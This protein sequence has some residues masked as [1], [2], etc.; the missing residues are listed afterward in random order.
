MVLTTRPLFPIS[1]SVTRSRWITLNGCV[2]TEQ[3][4]LLAGSAAFRNNAEKAWG[5]GFPKPA[6]LKILPLFSLQGLAPVLLQSM[7]ISLLISA[8]G[9]SFWRAMAPD[10]VSPPVIML[11]TKPEQ[12]LF[13]RLKCS[14]L[15][16]PSDQSSQPLFVFPIRRFREAACLLLWYCQVERSLLYPKG[17][18]EA[19]THT[20]SVVKVED[21]S[22]KL[23]LHFFA[24]YENKGALLMYV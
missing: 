7:I 24:F 4:R 13:C 12:L 3:T 18:Y 22:R 8:R 20:Q 1:S 11:G 6:L 17:V 9:P 5:E 2:S 10:P 23:R 19:R 16:F 14:W 21:P 15:V